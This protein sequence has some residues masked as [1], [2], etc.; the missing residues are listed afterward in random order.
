MKK[1][2]VLLSVIA[3][4][5][6]MLNHVQTISAGVEPTPFKPEINKL[7]SINLNISAISRHIVGLPYSPASPE[8]V[9][10]YLEDVG[11]KLVDLDTRLED[12]LVELP[13]PSY[14]NPFDGQ[15]AILSSL[16][17]MRSGV[18]II[19]DVSDRMGVEPTPFREAAIAVKDNAQ[20]IINRVN[21]YL[22]PNGLN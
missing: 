14:D 1:A 19:Y 9:Q 10:M 7:S 22:S 15:D 16:D 20:T 4:S 5:F 3:F 17:S 8:G 13:M 6:F 18:S 11:T 12:V 21:V 2:I